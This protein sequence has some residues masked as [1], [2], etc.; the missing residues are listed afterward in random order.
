LTL[1][2]LTL[3]AH[4]LSTHLFHPFIWVLQKIVASGGVS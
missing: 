2:S 1:S 4:I 3:P